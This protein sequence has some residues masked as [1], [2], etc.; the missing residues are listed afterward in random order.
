MNN[1]NKLSELSIISP[2]IIETIKSNVIRRMNNSQTGRYWQFLYSL[3]PIGR[4]ELRKLLNPEELSQAEMEFD[5]S[6]KFDLPLDENL[7][8]IYN[9]I[10]KDS[11]IFHN[12]E[13][14]LKEKFRTFSGILLNHTNSQVIFNHDYEINFMDSE[15]S[16]DSENSESDEESHKEDYSESDEDNCIED[17]E[18]FKEDSNGLLSDN[19]DILKEIA[20]IKGYLSDDINYLTK[21]YIQWITEDPQMIIFHKETLEMG[22]KCWNYIEYL[23]TLKGFAQF[24]IPLL[25]IVASEASCER[26]FWHQRRILGDQGGRTS[27]ELEKAKLFFCNPE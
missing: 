6:E 11:D 15:K 23:P 18:I 24:V 3:T 8:Q 1:L 27:I 7:N 19:I 21:V 22:I 5:A 13:I 25:G 4:L 26:A 17:S 14:Q 20:Q 16:D 12:E 2:D 9:D 10:K